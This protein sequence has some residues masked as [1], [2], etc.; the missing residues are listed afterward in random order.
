EW[1]AVDP[2]K[3][4]PI[5]HELIPLITD[6]FTIRPAELNFVA[7]LSQHLPP[8]KKEI[9]GPLL[10][11]VLRNRLQAEHA[12]SMLN[13]DAN[14][15]AEYPFAEFV[16]PWAEGELQKADAK[17]RIREDLCFAS[18]EKHWP[19]ARGDAE[20]DSFAALKRS[21][22]ASVRQTLAAWHR[23]SH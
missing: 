22:A 13:S 14:R 8:D 18:S 23:G 15:H 19:N 20:S 16:F 11:R 7:M 6:R 1:V 17:R 2:V 3:R 5:A 10:T 4:L 9:I 12:A 21:S